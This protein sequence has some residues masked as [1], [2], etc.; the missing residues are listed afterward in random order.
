VKRLTTTQKGYGHMHQQ[1]REQWALVVKTGKA[2]CSR[3]GRMIP[4][5]APWDLDHRD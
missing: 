5:D 1:L 2:R 3:C 4:P